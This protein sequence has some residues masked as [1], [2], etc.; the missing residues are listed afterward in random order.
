M[1]VS[2]GSD[3]AGYQL[4]SYL[5]DELTKLGYTLIDCGTDGAAS[6]DYPDFA[7]K[8]CRLVQNGDVELG[9]VICSTGIGVS[10][11]ANK[12]KG[13][14]AALCHTEFSARMSRLHNNSNVLAIGGAVLGD[15][16]ALAIAETFLTGDFSGGER[17][18]RR[19]GKISDLECDTGCAP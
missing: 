19:I 7:G 17:H 12:M 1:K 11:A 13:I 18:I 9:I 14:R 6:V 16:L 4:K 10:I 3:H 2:I 15:K 5:I 8:T